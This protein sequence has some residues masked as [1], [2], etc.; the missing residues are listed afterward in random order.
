MKGDLFGIDGIHPKHYMTEAVALTNCDI[1]LIP[2]KVLA[3][4]GR[5]EPA[6]ETEFHSVMCRE[7][8]REQQMMALLS[9]LAAEAR[10]ARF[11]VHLSE[12][13]SQLGYSGTQYNLRM[14]RQEIGSYLGLTLETVSRT[15]SA[16][17]HLGLITVEGKSISL[18]DIE[19]L[20]TMRRLP[21]SQ[22]KKAATRRPPQ[23][24][25][26]A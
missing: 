9:S 8:I 1:V 2:F 16:F 22:P 19:T 12:R 5:A 17:N 4:I 15:L 7:L 21:P 14:T 3:A 11:L 10:V 18:K 25:I 23:A 13:F 20:R 26:A 6:M 24:V